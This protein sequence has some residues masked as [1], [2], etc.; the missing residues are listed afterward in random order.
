VKKAAAGLVLAA[1]ALAGCASARPAAPAADRAR[2]GGA[3]GTVTAPAASTAPRHLLRLGYV[4]DIP[5]AEA[6]IGLQDGYLREDLGPGVHLELVPYLTAAAESADLADGRLDAAYL[7]PVAAVGAWQAAH[8]TIRIISGAATGYGEL[9]VARRITRPGQLAGEQLATPDGTTAQA[10]L[11]AWLGTQGHVRTA[12]VSTA[13]SGA[14]AVAAF[15]AGRIAGAWEPAPFDAEMVAAGGHVLA[16]ESSAWPATTPDTSAVLA[17]TS[18]LLTGHPAVI[19]G[20][21]KAQVQAEDLLAT[22][23][24]ATRSAIRAQLSADGGHA[25]ARVV[26]AAVSEVQFTDNPDPAAISSEAR[27]A[28]RAGILRP[29]GSLDGLYDLQPLNA[30]LKS[31]GQMLVTT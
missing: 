7:D 2:A 22:N 20:L 17:V 23:V 21:L 12:S 4:A 26:A 31:A 9:V 10:A 27:S 11:A 30:V 28:A 1:I 15:K 16:S 13:L 3:V 8:G 29:I 24:A 14:G 19:N 6:L 25:G 18:E 5:D